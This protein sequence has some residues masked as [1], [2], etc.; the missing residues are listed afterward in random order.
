MIKA[1]WIILLLFLIFLLNFENNI[2]KFTL[3]E[4]QSMFNEALEDMADILESN[5][6]SY[7]LHSGTALGAIRENKFIEN[8]EDIDIAIFE[9]DKVYNLEE[10]VLNSGKFK[11]VHKLPK[12]SKKIMEISFSHKKTKVKIDIFFIVE[13]N[14]KY[15][16]Y[17][18]FGICDDKPNKRCEYVNTKYKLKTTS[19]LGRKYKVPENKFLVEQY[20]EDWRTPKKWNYT[21]GLEWGY[22]NLQ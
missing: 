21:Q 7:H 22:K 18:Y 3:S 12:N 20:G 6:V 17:S 11:L 14:N 2:E 16:I 10:M 15:K 1:K 13:E 8:D 9:K 5:N 19:L 4:K